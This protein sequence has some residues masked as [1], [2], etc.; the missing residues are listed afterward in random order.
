MFQGLRV[1]DEKVKSVRAMVL[2]VMARDV[3]IRH[4]MG[5]VATK[6][7]CN[8]VLQKPCK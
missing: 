1:Q 5:N 8:P 3:D 2:D 7:A 4:H 6:R